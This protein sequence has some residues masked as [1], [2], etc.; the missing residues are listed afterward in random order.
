VQSSIAFTAMAGGNVSAAVCAAS[1][2]NLLGVVLTPFYAM[3]LLS[4]TGVVIDAQSVLLIVMQIVVP[5]GLGQV[6]HRRIGGWIE[7][8][9]RLT[10]F[11]DRGSILL[12]VYSAFSA[13]MVAGVWSRLDPWQLAGVIG[14]DLVLLVAVIFGLRGLGRLMRLPEP[15]RLT[16]LFCGMQKSLATGV[17]IANVLFAGHAVSIIILPL[18]LYHQVQLFVSAGLAQHHARLA[19]ARHEAVAAP[20]GGR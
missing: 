18:M 1:L 10:T 6:L 4:A 7:R 11:V 5:F 20:A 8:R 17:P 15:D 16:L 19:R 2:S 13:G 12:I 3:L 9:K 14:F